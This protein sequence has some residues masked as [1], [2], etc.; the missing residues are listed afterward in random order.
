MET[1]SSI[2]AGIILWKKSRNHP[3]SVLKIH[4][5][6]SHAHMPL[7]HCLPKEVIAS[8]FPHK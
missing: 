4:N 6:Q 3:F 7:G 2:L 5:N 8:Q 1:H